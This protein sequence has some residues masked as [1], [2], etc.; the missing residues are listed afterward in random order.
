MNLLKQFLIA[1][2][3]VATIVLTACSNNTAVTSA[4][5]IVWNSCPA[6]WD[7]GVSKGTPGECARVSVPLRRDKATG[8]TIDLAVKRFRTSSTSSK[9]IVWY[10]D[11]GP[12]GNGWGVEL[13]AA[14]FISSFNTAGWDVYVPS[15]RGTPYSGDGTEVSCAVGAD[16]DQVATCSAELATIWHNEQIGFSSYEEAQDIKL[17]IDDARVANPGKKMVLWAQ[18]Y[19]PYVVQR[20][21][22][23]YP[24][25][26]DVVVLDS[27]LPLGIKNIPIEGPLAQEAA[28][29]EYFQACAAISQCKDQLGTDPWA[30]ARK[31]FKALRD[32]TCAADPQGQLFS[33]ILGQPSGFPL[34]TYVI[35]ARAS[36]CNAADKL[37]LSN[38]AANAR[39]LGSG[40][41]DPSFEL[42]ERAFLNRVIN[43]QVSINDIYPTSI[44][45]AAA[46]TAL[47]DNLVYL[48][49][50]EDLKLIK[51]HVKHSETLSHRNDVQSPVK[52]PT[53]I[54]QGNLDMATPNGYFDLVV[55]Q[56]KPKATLRL[57]VG[58]HSNAT[59][60]FSRNTCASRNALAFINNPDAPLTDATCAGEGIIDAVDFAGTRPETVELVKQYLGGSL[61]GI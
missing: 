21:L 16:I 29:K 38:L 34:L 57:P 23:K 22:Q 2:A 61:W 30:T 25:S 60:G 59:N 53:L 33:V 54:V 47:K 41:R 39:N 9:G 42:P 37:A 36:R 11:G 58:G 40:N 49:D 43:H 28:L 4:T 45:E 10:I 52:V 26:A 35:A 6:H 8:I 19:G 18:S 48:L 1:T 55:S 5:K 50:P 14:K 24:T 7:N 20:F 51:N 13:Q 17:L 44:D 56:L 27:V 3:F 15:E 31:G 46:N 32:G 12:G